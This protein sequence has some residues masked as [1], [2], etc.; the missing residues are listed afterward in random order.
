M[1]SLVIGGLAAVCLGFFVLALK[2]NDLV[3]GDFQEHSDVYIETVNTRL[4]PFSE[5]YL[6]GDDLTAGGPQVAA[7]ENAEPVEATMSGPQVYNEACIACHGPG[8]GGAPRYGDAAAW[9]PRIEQGM[10]VLVEHAIS[11]YQGET[12]FMP[13][14]GGRMDLSDEEVAAAVEYIVS[15]VQ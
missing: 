6:P 3:R 2:L 4:Q 10:E 12:G 13:P 7:M 14:K 15:E 8:I 5:V 1:Y 9:G 11:G